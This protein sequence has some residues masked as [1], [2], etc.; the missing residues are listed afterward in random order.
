MNLKKYLMALVYIISS[1]FILTLILTI[2][3]Y[4]DLVSINV[5]KYLKLFAGI[6]S[7]LIGGLYIGKNSNEKGYLEGIKLGSIFIFILFL[8][9]IL[10]LGNG[11]R[12]ALFIYYIILIA[13]SMLG[14][15]IG[16]NKKEITQ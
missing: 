9:N 15:M 1:L 16:I 14:S 2:L 3:N 8:F 4:F 5:L 13:S 12:F 10:G 11:I 7:L 6:L